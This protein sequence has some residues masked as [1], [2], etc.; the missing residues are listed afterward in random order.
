MTYTWTEIQMKLENF[1]IYWK[2]SV[3]RNMFNFDFD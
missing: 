2:D 3:V 1:L